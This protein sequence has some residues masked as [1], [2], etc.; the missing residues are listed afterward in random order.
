LNSQDGF[1]EILHEDDAFDNR[2]KTSYAPTQI[3]IMKVYTNQAA[4]K[5]EDN[6]QDGMYV[7]EWIITDPII[8]SVEFGTMDYS[9][10]EPVMV[11]ITFKPT[12]PSSV[13]VRSRTI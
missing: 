2:W 7:N 11:S 4:L 3:T 9:S 12:S 1:E 13:V 8:E 6:S 5:K 10:E